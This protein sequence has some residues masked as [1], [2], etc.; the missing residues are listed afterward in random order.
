MSIKKKVLLTV[1]CG[2]LLS[3]LII[4]I[5]YFFTSMSIINRNIEV[6]ASEIQSTIL[7]RLN[8]VVADGDRINYFLRMNYT[9]ELLELYDDEPREVD[10]FQSI[11][12]SRDLFKMLEPI[13]Q[14]Q[15]YLSGFGIYSKNN[16]LMYHGDVNLSYEE[17]ILAGRTKDIYLGSD[18]D[19]MIPIVRPIM[20][21]QQTIGSTVLYLNSESFFYDCISGLPDGTKLAVH[22]AGGGELFSTSKGEKTGTPYT[23][24]FTDETTNLDL[25]LTLPKETFL[26]SLTENLR[27]VILLSL[28]IIFIEV[29][30]TFVVLLRITRN[31]NRLNEG[32]VRVRNQD[33]NA[34]VVIDS[35]DELRDM[36]IVFNS[37]V[38]NI[39]HLIAENKQREREKKEAEIDFL[40]AQ[41]NPHFLSNTLNSI[42]WMAKLQEANN[43][44]YLSR[45]LVEL[46]QATMYKG[47]DFITIAEGVAHVKNYVAI[48]QVAY[49]DTFQVFYEIDEAIADKKTLRF[50]LQ[51]LV[52]NSIIHNFA[53]Q[54]DSIQ[55][56][57]Y[58]RGYQEG[59][60]L[61]LE[62]QDNGKGIDADILMEDGLLKPSGKRRYS[63]IGVKNIDKR[64]KLFFGEEYGIRYESQI[65]IYTKAILRLP[66]LKEGAITNHEKSRNFR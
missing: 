44:A 31:I 26:G 37:M 59:S 53:N 36:G 32:M 23:R 12:L 30:V 29:V 19:W 9:D 14:Y 18:K 64:I 57:I 24:T 10:T 20:I 33:L 41:I 54:K 50:I 15:H 40:Q 66:I 8:E 48:Q 61:I 39:N 6:Q 25:I 56:E 13:Y 38:A 35:N 4:V 3:F 27:G 49:M 17:K 5:F 58:I 7:Q 63:R 22:E 34:T 45:A 11:K 2:N 43:I 65:D 28:I 46:L 62:I 1:I 55:G 47:D 52:E 60:D 21:N 51:P 42:S 16:R